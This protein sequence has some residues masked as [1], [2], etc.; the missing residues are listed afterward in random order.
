MHIIISAMSIPFTTTSVTIFLHYGG[1]EKQQGAVYLPHPLHLRQAVQQADGVLRVRL[2]ILTAPSSNAERPRRHGLQHCLIQVLGDER[3][4]QLTQVVLQYSCRVEKNRVHEK[5]N[6]CSK[7]MSWWHVWQW[8]DHNRFAA[9]MSFSTLD[10]TCFSTSIQAGLIFDKSPAKC[11]YEVVPLRNNKLP[12]T[13]NH[14]ALTWLKMKV[15]LFPQVILWCLHRW[16]IGFGHDSAAKSVW[17]GGGAGN[18]M[19]V[20]ACSHLWLQLPAVQTKLW[21]K[22]ETHAVCL[23]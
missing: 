10:L 20:M 9:Y 17:G 6:C 23:H 16:L 22:H 8:I 1:C 21:G 12:W 15:P 19:C 18:R 5:K 14:G 2:V 4:R 3:I 7:I 11:L 13:S